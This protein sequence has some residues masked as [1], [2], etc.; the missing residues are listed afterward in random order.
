MIIFDDI[1][2][3]YGERQVFRS[4]SLSLPDKV[5]ILEGPSGSGKTT[6]LK[7]AARLLKPQAGRISGVPERVSFTFQENTLLPWFT[8]RGNVEAVLP[9]DRRSEA[10]I[11]LKLMELADVMDS[12]PG[13]MSGGQQRRVAIARALA[14]GGELFIMDEPLKGLDEPLQ[15]RIVPRILEQVP[16]LIVTSHSAFETQLWGG[17]AVDIGAVG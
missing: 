14:Y 17:T 16:R 13:N 10:E 8:A 4:F 7:M 2:F 15:R 5:T 12:L 3:A 6:L 1:S 9:R 11:W